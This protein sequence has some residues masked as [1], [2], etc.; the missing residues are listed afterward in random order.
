MGT[1]TKLFLVATIVLVSISWSADATVICQ[2]PFGAQIT[3]DTQ[4][5]ETT[6]NGKK[7]Y[8]CCP[9]EPTVVNNNV[10][11]Q[12]L[13]GD[14]QATTVRP[15]TYREIKVDY[16][17]LIPSLL[18]SILVSICLSVLCCMLC[19][20]C[21][22]R[23]GATEPMGFQR[24]NEDGTQQWGCCCGIPLGTMAFEPRHPKHH[25]AHDQYYQP[26]RP[27]YDPNYRYPPADYAYDERMP[28]GPPR[29]EYYRRY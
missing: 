19:N 2:L 10:N 15:T 24:S 16:T 17:W 18:I 27:D 23:R 26:R 8:Y 13:G 3:C 28:R 14:Q 25:D 7:K 12:R 4:C 22:R 9:A 6:E 5:C 29:D 21:C 1:T 20:G 11:S